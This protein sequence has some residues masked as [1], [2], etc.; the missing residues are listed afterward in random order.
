[1]KD[2]GSSWSRSQ[3][4]RGVVDDI[5]NELT[6]IVSEMRKSDLNIMM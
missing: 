5:D 2:L 1:M 4:V 3:K 6:S